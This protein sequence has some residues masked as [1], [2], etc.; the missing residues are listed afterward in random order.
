LSLNPRAV[1]AKYQKLNLLQVESPLLTAT[2]WLSDTTFYS[3]WSKKPKIQRS[4]WRIPNEMINRC[5]IFRTMRLFVFVT[6]ATG[7]K[8]QKA[9]E[10]K[11]FDKRPLRSF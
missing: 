6:L 2:C 1:F 10:H 8:E 11:W 7:I 3:Y 5:L 9:L 4:C